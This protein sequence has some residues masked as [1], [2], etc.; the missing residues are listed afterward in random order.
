[1]IFLPFLSIIN[2]YT[3]LSQPIYDGYK[4]LIASSFTWIIYF[5]LHKYKVSEAT[6][7]RIFLYVSFFIVGVQI[8][9]QFTYPRALF[10]IRSDNNAITGAIQEVAEQRNGIWRFR[11]H[12]NSYFTT[13]ILFAAWLWLR[14]KYKLNIFLV[15]S[16]LLV[17]VYLTLTR[18]VMV[19]TILAIFLSFFMGTQRM[20]VK[21]LLLGLILISGLYIFYDVLFESMAEQTKDESQDNIRML[22]AAYFWNESIKSPLTFLFGYGTLS[23]NSPVI[24][25]LTNFQL[26][27]GF[28]RSDV[29]FIGQ[30]YERGFLYVMACYYLMY[31]LLFKLK[32]NIPLYIRMFVIFTAVMS[33]MIFP[34][35]TPVSNIVWTLL[36]YVSDL[37]INKSYLAL[38]NT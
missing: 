21:Y 36:L 2:S 5:L 22:S 13:P 12:F 27:N 14:Q 25:S 15:V 34:M 38:K 16:L 19:A 3:L 11:M 29:G 33:V 10:G 8:I 24:S 37:H 1:M 4:G 28:Y 26:L 31:R 17:S 20:N 35:I 30:I 32:N 6:V 9:Q 7:L 18:Q 23:G